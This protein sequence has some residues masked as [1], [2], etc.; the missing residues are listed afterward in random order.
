[1]PRVFFAMLSVAL[2][3][4]VYGELEPILVLRLRD[5]DASIIQMGMTLSIYS[6]VYIIGTLLVP[7]IPT[8]IEKRFTL[9][10]GM[11][12]L[13]AFLTLVGPSQVLGFEESFT[14]LIIGL[15]LSGCF[16]APTTIPVLPEMLEATQAMFPSSEAQE[17]ANNHTAALFNF[18][19]GLG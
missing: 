7:Q 16:L 13:G 3:N 1:M 18:G 17:A 4:F 8:R 12:L 6:I 2:Q 5:F 19:I 14:M 15:S 11:F 10:T 9:I